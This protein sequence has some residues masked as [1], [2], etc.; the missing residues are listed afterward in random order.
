MKKALS[1]TAL[2][3]AA[4][5]ASSAQRAAAGG[6]ELKMQSTWPASLTL[7]DNFRFFA[8]RVDKLTGGQVKIEALAAGQ[9]VPAF[10]ILDA[11][12][13]K[14]IDGGHG[15]AYYWV[16][17][18]KAATLFS[19]TPAGPFGMDHFDFLGWLHEGGGN[20][21]V[22]RV[23]PRRSQAQRDRHADRRLEPAGARLV[24]AADQGP[25]GLQGTEVPADRHRLR[26]LPAHGH[27]DGEHARR[28][29]RALG[30]ARRDRLRRVGRRH[31]GPAPRPAAGVEVPLHAR[32][33]TRATRCSS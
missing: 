30:A 29:D 33:C 12:H 17:K 21:A 24:Q 25:Q 20:G 32:A 14:V 7:Q 3:A 10:E 9:I 31:R 13:K 11:T 4:A 6:Q 26:D 28:R 2:A 19:A 18:N 1:L 8:E 5:L 16:G 22:R 27:A 15:V 23:L